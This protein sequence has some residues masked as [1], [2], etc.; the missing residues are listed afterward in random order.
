MQD[1]IIIKEE[2]QAELEKYR[3]LVIA[4]IDY[5]LDNKLLYFKTAEYDSE[6]HFKNM[7]KQAEEPCKKGKLTK[8][9]QWFRDM[10]EMQIETVDLKFNAYLKEKTNYDVDIFKSFFQ[11]IDT[12]IEKGKITTDT[13][14][15]DINIMINELCQT[16]PVD[17]T[18]IEI[19]NKL[20]KDYEQRK[21]KRMKKHLDN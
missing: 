20:V 8:L 17:T 14:F 10:T 21:A 1:N 7:Q 16:Q 4:T 15:Y 5:Y 13:Q 18:K 9:K 12:L 11:R 3:D 6:E 2:K 19:L